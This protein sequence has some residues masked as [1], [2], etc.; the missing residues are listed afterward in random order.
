MSNIPWAELW[1]FL[2]AMAPSLIGLITGG[3]AFRF[4]VWFITRHDR[5]RR[6]KQKA[7]ADEDDTNRVYELAY[8]NAREYGIQLAQICG[9]AVLALHHNQ[10]SNAEVMLQIVQH[11]VCEQDANGHWKIKPYP[12]F[13]A[14]ARKE[15]EVSRRVRDG[16]PIPEPPDLTSGGNST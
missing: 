10:I 11:I 7:K 1:K 6:E 16:E 9:P 2:Q 8:R 14:M 4:F 15:L 13:V 12:D 5:I 3:F